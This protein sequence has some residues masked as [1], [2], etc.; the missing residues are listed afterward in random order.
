MLIDS[1]CHLKDNRYAKDVQTLVSDAKKVGVA[2]FINIGTSL[3]SSK[4]AITT[5]Q[6]FREVYATVGVYPHEN[7]KTKINNLM[8]RLEELTRQ[9]KVV[10]IGECGIDI[11]KRANGRPLAEQLELFEAQIELAKKVKLPLT[12]HNRNGDNH[13]LAMLR[14]HKP[15]P[16]ILHCFSSSWEFARNILELG[17]YISFSAF[18]TYPSR[19]ELLETVKQV[20]LDKFVL[21]TDAPYLPPQGMRGQVNEPKNVKIVAEKVAEIKSLPIDIVSTHAYQ[22]TCAV[23]T[24]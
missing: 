6:L 16:G 9:E 12:I 13:I 3:T 22:N 24:L 20:P 21:E 8:P 23:L 19:K 4:E 18:I 7:R 2:K 5:A 10:A 15:Q 17:F 1:H 14:K 11:S